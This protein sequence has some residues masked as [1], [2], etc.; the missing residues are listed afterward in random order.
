AR[1]DP[2]RHQV[3]ATQTLSWTNTGE[4]SVDVLPFHLYLN[5]FKNEQ[6][7]FMRSSH[8]ELRRATATDTGWGYVHIDSVRVAGA[9]LTAK[10]RQPAGAGTDESVVELPLA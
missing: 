7:L 2:V 3:T 8:G 10:L 4:S 9:D 6:S 5:A 1:L